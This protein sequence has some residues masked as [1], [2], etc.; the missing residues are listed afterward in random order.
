MIIL[1]FGGFAC[2]PQT[3]IRHPLP[4]IINYKSINFFLELPDVLNE[5]F[6]SVFRV[7]SQLFQLSLYPASIQFLHINVLAALLKVEPKFTSLDGIP[8]YFINKL[9]L[10][11]SSQLTTTFNLSLS[12][13]IPIG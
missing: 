12:M 1:N 9:A 2:Y 3:L 7:A 8:R 4:M 10:F 6:S 13:H 11:I 5:F